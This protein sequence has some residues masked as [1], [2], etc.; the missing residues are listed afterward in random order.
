MISII[1]LLISILLPAL[2]SARKAAQAIA[3]A[4]N[5]RQLAIAFHTYATDHDSWIP[6]ANM[7]GGPKQSWASRLDGNYLTAKGPVYKCPSQDDPYLGWLSYRYPQTFGNLNTN[8]EPTPAYFLLRNLDRFKKPMGK[9]VML[10]DANST[11]S[12]SP[13]WIYSPGLG[14]LLDSPT[15]AVAALRHY[16]A[17]SI[18]V[19]WLDGHVAPQTERDIRSWEFY[20][21]GHAG[22]GGVHAYPT[23]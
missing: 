1:S 21:W 2:G 12:P 13:Q 15:Y 20:Q 7:N 23:Y 18:N 10:I 19:T 22:G 11:G 8:W 17:G 16:G 5:L 14:G 3:C 9:I 4:S 6:P